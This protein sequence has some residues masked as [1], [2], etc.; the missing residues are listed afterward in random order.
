MTTPQPTEKLEDRLIKWLLGDD[1]GASSKAICK[2]MLGI[3]DEWNYSPPMDSGDRGR[4]IRLLNLIPE[5]WDRLDEM[6]K[7]PSR[8]VFQLSGKN[9]GVI[10]QGWAEQIPLIREESLTTNKGTK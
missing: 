2:F 1:T 4:C 7:I 10:S 3:P 9:S 6:A 5:W 8:K